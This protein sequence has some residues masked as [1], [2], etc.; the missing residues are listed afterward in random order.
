MKPIKIEFQA[1]GPYTGH[2][3]VDFEAISSKGLF[4]ICGK[5]GIGKTMILDAMTFALYGKSSGNVRDDF[6]SMRSTN[7]EFNT[8]TFVKF[9][10]ENNGEYFLFERRLERKRTNLS[11]S[12]SMQKKGDDGVWRPIDTENPKASDLNAKAVELIGLE[13]SQFSQVIVLP[14]GKFEKLLT[15]NSDEKEK[16]LTSIFGEE[17]WKLIA[18]KFF[19]EAQNRKNELDAKKQNIDRSIRDEGC[20]TLADLSL[21]IEQKQK[22]L[23]EIT[24]EFK[25][26]D[27]SKKKEKLQAQLMLVNT[28]K[29]L[30]K[31]EE[32]LSELM[33]QKEDRKGWED[34]L[35]WGKKAENTRKFI[36]AFDSSYT[37]L[38]DRTDDE[39]KAASGKEKQEKIFTESAEKYKEL[40]ERKTEIEDKKKLV[41]QYEGKITDYEGLEAAEEEVG[42]LKKE[43][44]NAKKQV[45]DAREKYE[46]Y[47]PKITGLKSTYD[48]LLHEHTV[49]LNTYLA[50]ITG[51]LASKL[52]EGKPCPVCGSTS[53]PKKAAVSENSVSKEEVDS[54]K[55]EA[56]GA[57]KNMNEAVDAQTKAKAEFDRLKGDF[58]KA[59]E[60]I[61][62]KET[63]LENMRKNMVEG[64]PSIAVLNSAISKLIREISAYEKALAEAEDNKTKA[65]TALTASESN[66]KACAGETK[67]AE[68]K[69]KK[70]EEALVKSLEEND[71]EDSD[72]AREFLLT[73]EEIEEFRS[74][75][76]DYDAAVDAANKQIKNLKKTIKDSSEPDEKECKKA[77]DE[78]DNIQVK[79]E[80]NKTLIEGEI[81]RLSSKK[82]AL[83]KESE[84][85]PEM[86]RQANDDLAFAKKL[87]GD[88]GTGLQR[89][90]LGI[91]FSQVIASANKMLEMVH[92]G[93]YRLFRSDDKV[94]GSNKRGL[95]LKVYD[96]HSAES[97]GR[98]VSTLSGGE[99]FLASL[100]LS[101]GMSTIAQKSGIKIEALFIDEGFGSLDE[102]SISDAMDILNSIQE[103]NGL[104]GIIS[105][106]QIL[107]DRIPSKLIVER[108]GN[109]SHIAQRIG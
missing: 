91:M 47:A 65:S 77:I 45:D 86:L 98:F 17:K 66:L 69:F 38:Q 78:L 93:R 88:S 68:N 95:D 1:F 55:K 8:A 105:H 60:E 3:V 48:D 7:A 12:Y 29:D 53:H 73:A 82:E 33:E 85:L 22:E 24:E 14:Q 58:D 40:A 103:A 70:A 30:H 36:E 62:Q 81:T 108:Q 4:L 99:K 54:K 106:V 31:Q 2:E 6:E 79:F 80:N 104:V 94:A 84:G 46:A 64:I 76:S 83:S 20:E 56:D 21:I 92:G 5:T 96:S 51:E 37:E 97:E 41:T 15:S 59:K 9:I 57:Y 75:I 109:G 74:S 32:E 16:I 23:E 90:V 28:F 101:I 34:T 44:K 19:E 25:K 71:F 18:E 61:I 107:Q 13:Y 39:N 52:E 87:R 72:Q 43:S 89:Y 10:F 27:I 49:L 102:D 100:A 42:K 63:N 50:G 35:E 67:K 26:E 11:A